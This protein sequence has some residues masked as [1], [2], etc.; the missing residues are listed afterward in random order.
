MTVAEG[1]GDGLSVIV[2]DDHDVV[3]WGFRVLLDRQPWVSRCDAASD[4]SSALE[5][6]G[7]RNHDVALVDLFLGQSSGAE[8]CGEIHDVSPDTDVLLVSG[9]GSIS[10]AVARAAGAS[11]FVSKDLSARDVINAVRMVSLG[12]EVFGSDPPDAN[13]GL[14]AREEEVLGLIAGG[15]TN[16]EIAERLFLSPHTVKDHTSSIYRKLNVRNRA[17]AVQRAQRIG[18][19]G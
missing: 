8:L 13:A 12:I 19:L 18:L 14:S 1:D 16:S 6:I 17:E 5:L 4:A 11:G 10:A 9:A 7:S 15:A 2:V 3:H